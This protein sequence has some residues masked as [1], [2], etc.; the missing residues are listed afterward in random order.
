MPVFK[1]PRAIV[2]C[3]QIRPVLPDRPPGWV[4][5]PHNTRRH[6]QVGHKAY[7]SDLEITEQVDDMAHAIDRL[8]LT[9]GLDYTVVIVSR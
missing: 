6:I 2:L 7:G 5:C 9:R 8:D 3:D 4:C 1:D